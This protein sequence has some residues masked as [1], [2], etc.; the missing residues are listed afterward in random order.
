MRILKPVGWATCL[1][2]VLALP[3]AMAQSD[4]LPHVNVKPVQLGPNETAAFDIVTG[5]GPWLEGMVFII[6]VHFFNSSRDLAVDLVMGEDDVVASWTLDAQ[7]PVQQAS[8]RIPADDGPYAL[9][10]QN[11]DEGE[12]QFFFYFDQTCNCALKPI[13][14]K[15][16]WVVFHYDLTKDTTYTIR[17]PLTEDWRV[18]GVLATLEEDRARFPDDFLVAAD[19]TAEAPLWLNLTVRPEQ[20]QRY[21]V[22]V[23]GEAGAPTVP[24]PREFIQLSAIVD[25]EGGNDGGDSPSLSGILVMVA[26]AGMA[27][28]ARRRA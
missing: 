28:V 21:Y 24:N 16:G 3:V 20:D 18:R 8:A 14:L 10:F 26:V 6:S 2:L 5:E 17:Y 7:A 1:L 23:F 12:T 19:Q 4:P 15:E 25:T 22:F 9:R 11:H 13:P 27:A